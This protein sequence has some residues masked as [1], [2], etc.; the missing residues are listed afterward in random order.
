MTQL[1]IPEFALFGET[2]AF[3][4]V[5][6][7][8]R[9]GDRAPKHGWVIEP[10]RHAEMAQLF[11][12]TAGQADVR[13]DGRAGQMGPGSYLFVPP[14]IVHG[15]AFEPET[16]GL[17][18]SF[19]QPVVN[20][21]AGMN[22]ALARA[23]SQPFAGCAD[24]DLAALF[25]QFRTGFAATGPFRA[26]V[27]VGLAHALL[28]RAA[29][30]APQAGEA[31]APTLLERLDTLIGQRHG[32]PWRPRDYA[33]A[34]AVTTGHLSRVCRAASGMG[35]A[36]YIERATMTEACRLL[37]F[38]QI[39]VAEVGYRLGYADP[40]YFSRRFRTRVGLPPS[41]YRARFVG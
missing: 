33:A 36:S 7:C 39:P 10:H 18:M 35:A 32:G 13:I 30:N 27:L 31:A 8:E 40:S 9:I 37:A 12:I 3:P 1:R 24:T 29:E 22:P 16:D 11:H 25:E 6:H 38:T 14:T 15:F 17:V 2:S 20:G 19:P 21:I 41:D 28:A 4:D 26:Q 5:V 34:L 23:L